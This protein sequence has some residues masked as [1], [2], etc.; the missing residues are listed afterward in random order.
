MDKIKVASSKDD[1]NN[2]HAF[3]ALLVEV[4]ERTGPGK[5]LLNHLKDLYISDR[6]SARVFPMNNVILQAFGSVESY[7][8]FREGQKNVIFNIEEAMHQYKQEENK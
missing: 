4:F 8:A 7:M 3:S 5:K 6:Y 1:V 2:A